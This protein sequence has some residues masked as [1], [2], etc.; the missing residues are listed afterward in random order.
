MTRHPVHPMLV[1]LP[2]ACW[3]LAPMSDVAALAMGRPFFWHVS[4]LL[5]AAG[6]VSGA[7]AATFGALEL[8]RIKDRKD[9]QRLATIHASLMGTAWVVALVAI[10]LRIDDILLTRIPGPVSVAVLDFAAAGILV[11]GA[12]FGGEMVYRH[13]VGVKKD[14]G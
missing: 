9:V 6:L 3:L 11:A 2:I 5:C 14:G 12:F 10:I 8:E 7:L 1:H 13:G 4:A